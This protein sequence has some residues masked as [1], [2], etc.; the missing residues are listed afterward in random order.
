MTKEMENRMNTI[1]F[2]LDGTLLPMDQD[3]FIQLYF[4]NLL[5]H[6]HPF[7]IEPQK[8]IKAVN[9]G[10]IAMVT[11]D[12][13]KT[14]EERF[15]EVFANEL[16]TDIRK[17]EP[18]FTKFYETTFHNAKASTTQ[19]P[20]AKECLKLLQEKGYL[21]IIATNPL[22]PKVAT[23]GRIGWAG[24]DVSD[25]S[26]VTTYETSSYCKPNLDYYREIIARFDKAPKDCLMVG[27]DVSE[28]MCVSE[29]GMQTYLV[30]DCLINKNNIS[31]DTIP[32]GTM[33]DFYEYIKSLPSC[34]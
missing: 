24:F 21:I 10:T 1:L 15:W 20:L 25:V 22:F 13:S 28:D 30:T 16:G 32:H 29:L 26:Y 14:N 34:K 19:N 11:N 18:E 3:Q 8:L 23:H 7:G 5:A 2:D 4:K 17:L 31:L 27:N 9:D 6:L 33:E 12:G